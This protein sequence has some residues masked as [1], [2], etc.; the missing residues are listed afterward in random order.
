MVRTGGHTFAAGHTFLLIDNSHTVNHV[1]R[2]EGTGLDTGTVSHTAID[3]GFLSGTRN[4][5]DLLAVIHA[6]VVVLDLRLIAGTLT[7]YKSHFLHSVSAVHAHDGADSARNS[8][9]AYRTGI[10]GCVT[11]SDCLC[12]SV[13]ACVS[14]AAAVIAWQ[15]VAHED[16][17]FICFYFKFFAGYT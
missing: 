10:H 2:V 4:D 9:S 5:C 17:F 11:R 3:A 7:F 16:L 6:V 12:Q 13:T 8:R 15:L 14:A 1:N